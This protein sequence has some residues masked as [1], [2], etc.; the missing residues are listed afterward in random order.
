M[1]DPVRN[2]GASVRAR[3]QNL[4]ETRE[5]P[6]QL[7]LTRF[8]LERLRCRLSSTTHRERF[9]LKGAM[10][11][12]TWFDDPYRPTQDLDRLGMGNPAWLR[13]RPGAACTRGS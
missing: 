3:L 5:Q 9:V 11:M 13:A 12:A 2:V 7:L 8:V 1:P 4:A 10:L 6:F